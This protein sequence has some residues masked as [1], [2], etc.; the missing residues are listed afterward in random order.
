MEG[1]YTKIIFAGFVITVFLL[2]GL[3]AIYFNIFNVNQKIGLV[4]DSVDSVFF[5]STYPYSSTRTKKDGSEST[6]VNRVTISEK[7]IDQDGYIRLKVK[8]PIRDIG[9]RDLDFTVISV[10]N[11]EGK[12]ETKDLFNKI[13]ANGKTQYLLTLL[14]P[15]KTDLEKVKSTL[16]ET[17]AKC[18]SKLEELAE[19]NDLK[20]DLDLT[21]FEYIKN[22]TET[23][24]NVGD[25]AVVI[26]I[27]ETSELE[28][29]YPTKN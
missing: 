21:I 24:I 27:M 10:K 2:L 23:P 19:K 17:D 25:L 5:N 12:M 18:T 3:G 8:T 13:K 28:K 9:T 29:K 16:C 26:R 11:E 1:K 7:S 15:R 4:N 14:S 6:S 20:A 22:S